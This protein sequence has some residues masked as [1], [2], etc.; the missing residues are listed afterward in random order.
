MQSISPTE[1]NKLT[2]IYESLVSLILLGVYCAKPI[3]SLVI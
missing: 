2:L 3:D 1:Y